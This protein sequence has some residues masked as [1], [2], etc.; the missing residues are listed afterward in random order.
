MQATMRL[1]VCLLWLVAVCVGCGGPPNVD[2]VHVTG[3]A[4]LDG[5]PLE[6][7]SGG[8]EG[9]GPYVGYQLEF[10][11]V[12]GKDTFATNVLSGGKFEL[13]LPTGK[14]KVT[15][16]SYD[17]TGGGEMIGESSDGPQ[18]TVEKTIEVEITG[19]QELKL[20]F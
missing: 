20:E 15:V 13:D 11:P 1:C 16:R 14:Y 12:D 17:E 5:K 2:T 19:S 10:V 8:G 7:K 4:T 9:G 18:Q 3:T 6:P